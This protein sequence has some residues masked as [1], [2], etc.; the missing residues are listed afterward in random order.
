M[1]NMEDAADVE[2][3]GVREA[4]KEGDAAFSPIAAIVFSVRSQRAARVSVTV[5]CHIM[6]IARVHASG[7]IFILV[8][9]HRKTD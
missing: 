4:F 7:R 8:V 5:A 6:R 9:E 2:E 1:K 3:K